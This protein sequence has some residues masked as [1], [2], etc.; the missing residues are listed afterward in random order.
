MTIC[1]PP[2]TQAK[3][4]FLRFGSVVAAR[5]NVEGAPFG[6]R[7]P[8]S[9]RTGLLAGWGSGLSAPWPMP[10]VALDRCTAWWPDSWTRL[11]GDRSRCHRWNGDRT[12]DLELYDAPES[13]R[14]DRQPGFRGCTGTRRMA[15]ESASDTL[16][17]RVRFLGPSDR[18]VDFTP[19]S[20]L[21]K[22]AALWS[23]GHHEEDHH[24][25][26]TAWSESG[27]A[28][29]QRATKIGWPR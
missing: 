2:Q 15:R 28:G 20:S 27:Y 21:R 9:V 22:R 10:V 12:G 13:H 14:H 17:T 8:I 24:D 26:K 18:L 3:K 29:P 4:P 5:E 1:R 6:V 11:R 16:E 23:S 19:S 25:K 7:L